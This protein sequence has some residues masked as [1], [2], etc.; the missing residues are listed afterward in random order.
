MSVCGAAI[1]HH[2]TR[3]VVFARGQR[4]FLCRT[5]QH[6]RRTPFGLA[7][8]C[9]AAGTLSHAAL[10]A[11]SFLRSGCG[12]EADAAQLPHALSGVS[13][14]NWKAAPSASPYPH[15]QRRRTGALQTQP[16]PCLAVPLQALRQPVAQTDYSAHCALR[17]SAGGWRAL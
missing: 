4:F 3:T 2:Q 9:G 12:Y 17:R 6:T 15:A 8:T 11:G 7:L 16:Q 10:A 1:L 5:P 13:N 14:D